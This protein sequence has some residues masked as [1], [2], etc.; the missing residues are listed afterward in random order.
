MQDRLAYR[1]EPQPTAPLIDLDH[2]ATVFEPIHWAS[3]GESFLLTQR[4]QHIDAK[5]LAR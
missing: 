5:S 3:I 4:R 2:V 1:L